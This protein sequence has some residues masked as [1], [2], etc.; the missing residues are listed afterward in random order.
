MRGTREGSV[1]GGSDPKFGSP[2]EREVPSP[3]SDLTSAEQAQRYAR[4]AGASAF[5]VGLGYH[6]AV[7]VLEG[8]LVYTGQSI[9]TQGTLSSLQRDSAHLFG[10]GAAT[11]LMTELFKT[12]TLPGSV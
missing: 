1:R 12:N 2:R 8:I 10:H 5:L 11:D 3:L 4:A 7:E 9:R 6:S